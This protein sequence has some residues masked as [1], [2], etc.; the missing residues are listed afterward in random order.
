MPYE[1]PPWLVPTQTPGQALVAGVNAGSGIA[2]NMLEARALSQRQQ[3]QDALL[4]LRQQL[5]QNQIKGASLD[6]QKGLFDQQNMLDGKA[7]MSSLAQAMADIT[8]D[9]LWADPRGAQRLW[10]VG[11]NN[12][13]VTYTPQFKLALSQ[14]DA[15]KAAKDNLEQSKLAAGIQK[16]DADR[17]ARLTI[18]RETNTSK[19]KINAL[20]NQTRLQTAFHDKLHEADNII[21]KA[22]L[23][24]FFNQSKSLWADT[25]LN[26]DEKQRRAEGLLSQLNSR[27]D[28]IRNGTAPQ[29]Q[30]PAV[31]PEHKDEYDAVQKQI[32]ELRSDAATQKISLAKDPKKGLLDFGEDNRAVKL[33]EIQTQIEALNKVAQ[34]YLNSPLSKPSSSATPAGGN[35]FVFMR[36]PDDNKIYKVP[37]QSVSKAVTNK[38]SIV[39]VAE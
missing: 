10:E 36:N 26:S 11:V 17:E 7:G 1:I 9:S 23:H 39:D 25:T 38:W 18:E 14:V 8:K 16:A 6:I 37:K 4:P 22:E 30:A 2:R 27:M 12:P 13:A 24:N 29:G 21:P 19:E 32:S 5:Y 31:D 34:G 20:T 15:A 28:A 33:K 3:E 35:D